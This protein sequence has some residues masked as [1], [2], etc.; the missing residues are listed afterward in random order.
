VILLDGERIMEGAP[1]ARVKI[2]SR[3]AGHRRVRATVLTG[4]IEAHIHM[5]P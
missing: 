2:P 5:F 1:A 3:H 4:M